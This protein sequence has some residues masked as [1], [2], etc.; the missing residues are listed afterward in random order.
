MY[1][2][3]QPLSVRALQSARIASGRID[4]RHT[5]PS[6]SITASLHLIY[7]VRY[8]EALEIRN[9]LN[10][11]EAFKPIR[12]GIQLGHERFVHAPFQLDVVH[13]AS[14]GGAVVSPFLGY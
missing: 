9:V 8:H 13:G 2:G 10:Y 6:R 7:E 4:A 14:R 12:K 5:L 3:S 11:A 1:F